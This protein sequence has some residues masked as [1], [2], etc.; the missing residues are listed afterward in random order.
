MLQMVSGEGVLFGGGWSVCVCALCYLQSY[1]H[2]KSKKWF[3]YIYT[4]RCL[5]I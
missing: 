4:R 5:F 1:L 2:E 3:C